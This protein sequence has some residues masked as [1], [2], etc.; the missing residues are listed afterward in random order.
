MK[1]IEGIK[2]K[3]RPYEIPDCSR[4]DLPEF[5]KEMGLNKGVEIGVYKGALTRRFAKEGL[6]IYGVDPYKPYV[7]FDI[8]EDNR[9]E[10]QNFLFRHATEYL[11]KYDNAKIIRKTSM[12]ALED[13]EDES[14]DFVYIDGNHKFK[15]IAEDMCE[16]YKKIKKGGVLCGHDYIHP[17]RLLN[18]EDTL[19]VKFVVDAFME[20]YRIK[21]W[22]VLGRDNGV[23]GEVRDRFR[24]WMLIK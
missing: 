10:R 1:I 17:R 6:E 15:Y 18:R 21:N 20:A 9:K 5:F 12:E 24:S 13:F 7:D 22:F 23:E 3:G 19:Q 8:I 4:N 2:E 16:W 11:K 14:L